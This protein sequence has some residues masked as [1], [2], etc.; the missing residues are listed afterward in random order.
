[1]KKKKILLNVYRNFKYLIFKLLYGKI[2]II[3]S[4]KKNKKITIKKIYFEGLAVYKLY[5][6][7]NGRLYSDTVNDTAFLLNKSL[8]RE[9]SFQYRYQKNLMIVNDNANKNFVIKKGTPKLIK[10]IKGNVFSL[11]AGGAAKNNYWHWLFDVLPRVGILNKSNFKLKPNYYL[12]P[13]LSKKYQNQ[14]LIQLKILSSSLIDGERYKHIT[15]DNLIA[16]DHPIN[17]KNNPSK[18]ILNIPVWIIK[19]LRKMYLNNNK[20]KLNLAKNFFINRE[21]DSNLSAR[22]IINNEEVKNNLINLGF[23]SITLSRLSFKHQVELFKNAKFIIG[24]HGAAFA[25]IVFSKPGTKIIEIASHDSGDVILN[26]AESCKLNY[27]RIVEKN[28]LSTLKFQNS[29]INV[30][31]NKLKKLI[32][33]FRSN[34]AY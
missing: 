11:L 33:S 12:L 15:C 7:P 27:K 34:K 30:N 22:K 25:N 17:F 9:P 2:K 28:L 24:L 4:A 32:L 1:M 23:K 3:Q 19:W 29:H 13:S 20:K 10:K 21:L 31:I 5:N 18:S 14:T 16:V 8:I 6:I 26:L